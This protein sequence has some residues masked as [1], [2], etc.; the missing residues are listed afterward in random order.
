[1]AERDRVT[2]TSHDGGSY[3]LPTGETS[4]P[5]GFRKWRT[6]DV[7]LMDFPE[8]KTV[9]FRGKDY[10][11]PCGCSKDI[12]DIL[13]KEKARYRGSKEEETGEVE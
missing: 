4:G 7:C 6:C 13:R 5:S 1:M 10:G 12:P 2:Y 9:K 8:E 11:V 3:T